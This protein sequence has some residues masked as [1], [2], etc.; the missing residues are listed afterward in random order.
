MQK[1]EKLFRTKKTASFKILV[2]SI[3]SEFVFWTQEI[4]HRSV[5]VVGL[6]YQTVSFTASLPLGNSSMIN[7]MMSKN[8]SRN[9]T[10]YPIS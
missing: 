10:A 7:L 8:S 9:F 2:F 4:P 3:F 1:N 5:F 6:T